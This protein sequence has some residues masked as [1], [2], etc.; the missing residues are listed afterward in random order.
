MFFSLSLKPF[1]H[2]SVR[3][4]RFAFIFYFFIIGRFVQEI[5]IYFSG[6]LEALSLRNLF[7]LILGA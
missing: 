7:G 2:Y 5:G 1:V 3:S 4:S 6:Y